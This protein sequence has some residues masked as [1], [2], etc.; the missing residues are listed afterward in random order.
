M[1]P[2]EISAVVPEGIFVADGIGLLGQCF[3]KYMCAAIAP[4]GIYGSQGEEQGTTGGGNWERIQEG[5]GR[6]SWC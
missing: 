4:S 6:T 5:K 1:I 2:V 3:L